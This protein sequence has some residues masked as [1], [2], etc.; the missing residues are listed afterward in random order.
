M[1]QATLVQLGNTPPPKMEQNGAHELS[2][3]AICSLQRTSKQS[4]LIVP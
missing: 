4:H 3:I 2:H 1:D